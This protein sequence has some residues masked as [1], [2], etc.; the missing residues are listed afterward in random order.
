M[1][2]PYISSLSSI[3]WLQQRDPAPGPM[4]SDWLMEKGSMTRRLEQF[5]GKIII[6]RIGE[7]FVTAASIDAGERKELPACERCWL[8]QVVIYGDNRPWVAARTI[9]P[10]TSLTG[11]QGALADAGDEPIG[12]RLFTEEP[13]L[14]DY[15]HIGRLD[16]LWARR[17]RLRPGGKPLL[18]TELFLPDAPLYQHGR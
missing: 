1:E 2:H 14:R 7:G 4:I 8:R 5:C 13:L 15:I 3:V 11:E 9:I 12:R 16:Q 18:L 17:S 6:H 10:E